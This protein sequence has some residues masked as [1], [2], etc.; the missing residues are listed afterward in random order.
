MAFVAAGALCVV[1]FIVW[2]GCATPSIT[3]S[4]KPLSPFK[5]AAFKAETATHPSRSEVVSKMGNP[6]EYFPDLRVACYKLDQVSSRTLCLFLGIL[7]IALTK[8]ADSLDVAMI[9]FDDQDRAQ[10]IKIETV[11]IYPGDLR[12]AADWWIKVP[13]HNP[14]P[15]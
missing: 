4:R 8:D 12:N 3:T 7:P 13:V 1:G 11:S 6:D 5:P 15:H 10:R 14:Q 9:Q 2:P